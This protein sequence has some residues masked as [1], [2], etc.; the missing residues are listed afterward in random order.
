M[1][2]PNDSETLWP[3]IDEDLAEAMEEW[4]AWYG[5]DA[6]TLANLYASI[7]GNVTGSRFWARSVA[8][9]KRVQLH[10][11]IASD[12]C[13][14]SAAMLFGES[15]NIFIEEASVPEDVDNTT[16]KAPAGKAIQPTTGGADYEVKTNPEALKTQERLQDIMDK[17]S[18]F[19]LLPEGAESAAAMGGVFLKVDWDILLADY[20]I[21]TLVQADA[22]I[23]EFKFRILTA[24]TF[25]RRV[26]DLTQDS[27]YYRHLER[28]EMD[29]A[30]NGVILHGLY[31]SSDEEKLGSKVSL[32]EVEE[33]KGLVPMFNTGIPGLLVRYVPNSR[34]NKRWRNLDTG[35]SD[36]SGS[37][38]LMDSLDE[39]YTGLMRDCR[40]GQGRLLIPEQ[41][42][43]QDGTSF[44]FDL[45][46]EAYSTLDIDP[47]TEKAEITM[48]QFDIR[49]ED[50]LAVIREL[51][52]RIVGVAGYSPQTFGMEI[53]GR[54]ESGIAL[55]VRERKSLSTAQKKSR[56]WK[57]AITDI[58][59]LALI[60]DA[61]ILNSGVT[62]FR[63]TVEIADGIVT[64]ILELS[65]TVT[66]L[67]AA[68]AVSRYQ[69]IKMIHPD[70]NDAD[71]AQ[72]IN[73]IAKDKQAAQAMD[74]EFMIGQD[75]LI[76]T[77]DT[78][79]ET[80]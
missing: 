53:E 63:P 37:E 42:L 69:M 5:G 49:S 74:A 24:V 68:D 44:S 6:T 40:L 34:P 12:L 60:V 62:P 4:A 31:K 29:E 3:P 65:Q 59:E 32:S 70:W 52:T 43:K 16:V 75:K 78:N 54:G 35:L 56:F 17:N 33:T 15:P 58:L 26:G 7:V 50:Y 28:H 80:P 36:L 11:P 71:I 18:F 21:I 9:D 77:E 64:D 73:R 72:E 76:G 41:F 66:A 2:L 27:V 8:E 47:M 61:Q 46:K 57:T 38:G 13:S 10:V 23:P 22:A 20:P 51:V 14:M 79:K 48:N 39:A 19:N 67:K 1:P 55:R 30:G 45:D 25:W